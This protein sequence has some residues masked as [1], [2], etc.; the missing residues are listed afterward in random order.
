MRN[1]AM[2]LRACIF[3]AFE[4]QRTCHY[5]IRSPLRDPQR[6]TPVN[7]GTVLG[8]ITVLTKDVRHFMKSVFHDCKCVLDTG[9]HTGLI[10]T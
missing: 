1:V 5:G 8:N 9:K 3:V 2:S 6:L 4:P 7:A 10:R